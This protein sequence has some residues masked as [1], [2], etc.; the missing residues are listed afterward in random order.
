MYILFLNVKTNESKPCSIQHDQVFISSNLQSLRKKLNLVTSAEHEHDYRQLNNKEPAGPHPSLPQT[1]SSSS[2][3]SSFHPKLLPIL[4][5]TPDHS[6]GSP[7]G[8]IYDRDDVGDSSTSL[9]KSLN[10]DTIILVGSLIVMILIGLKKYFL[11]FRGNCEA[12]SD[13]A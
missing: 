2:S 8:S 1:T 5:P 4:P 12:I 9:P 11:F 3:S 7:H 10:S 6:N 13:G